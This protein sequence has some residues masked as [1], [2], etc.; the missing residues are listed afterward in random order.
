MKDDIADAQSVPKVETAPVAPKQKDEKPQKPVAVHSDTLTTPHSKFRGITMGIVY[1]VLFC[2]VFGGG[3]Y[4]YMKWDT[5]KMLSN[6]TDTQIAFF[7]IIPKDAVASVHYKMDSQESRNMVRQMWSAAALAESNNATSGDPT[8]LLSISDIAEVNYVLLPGNKSPYLIVEKTEG[9]KQFVAQ[10][11][12]EQ[13][14]EKGKWYVIHESKIGEYQAALDTGSIAENSALLASTDS[15]SYMIRYALDA[16]FVSQQFT[17]PVAV[18]TRLSH[19]DALVF[20]VAGDSSDDTIRASALIAGD[21]PG[22]GVVE[23]TTE[24]M[25]LI[26]NDITFGRVGLNFAEDTKLLPEDTLQFDATTLAQPAVRQ[27]I[28]LF[29][30]P[31]AIFERKGSDGVPDIGLILALPGS[32][33]QKIKNGEPIIEQSLPALIPLIIGKTL[34]VQVAFND[35]EYEKIPLRYVNVIG[36]TQSLDYVVGDNFLLISSSREGMNALLDT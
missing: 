33:K 23:S 6:T 1:V 17:S 27:F 24:L 18:A 35:G 2:A 8:S 26:P 3:I 16:A 7:Q 34:G 28:A 29:T 25:T 5:I 30:T 31:Y 36:Q 4:G 9:I 11:S 12:K 15:S 13:V 10:Y 21:P 19:M 20:H 14:L 32:L 22:E